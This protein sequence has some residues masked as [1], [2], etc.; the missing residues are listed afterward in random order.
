MFNRTS[1]ILA[2]CLA[3]LPCVAQDKNVCPPMHLHVYLQDEE[4]HTYDALL[5]A[6]QLDLGRVPRGWLCPVR[7]TL[8][9]R[10]TY[11]IHLK[12]VEGWNTT[13]KGEADRWLEAGAKENIEV[14]VDTM[15]LGRRTI[16]LHFDKPKRVVA[17]VKILWDPRRDLVLEPGIIAFGE[18]ERGTEIEKSLRIR[19]AGRPDWTV[20][21]NC[22]DP[23]I[24]ASIVETG[25]KPIDEKNWAITYELRAKMT[26][27][28]K[29]GPI[30]SLIQLKTNDDSRPTFKIQAIGAVVEP[31]H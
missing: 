23:S 1:L 28:A 29:P 2:L 27:D 24:A 10:F 18:A 3:A 5:D 7:I 11:R 19:Y 15:G 12:S 21:T 17:E 13:V 16:R 20:S 8:T 31:K 30:D 4:V 9:N 26:P 25:R 14:L 22:D 6:K